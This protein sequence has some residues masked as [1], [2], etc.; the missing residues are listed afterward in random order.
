M[1]HTV[2]SRNSQ[3]ESVLLVLITAGSRALMA[4]G[5][6]SSGDT[7]FASA[8]STACAIWTHHAGKQRVLLLGSRLF[9]VG[10]GGGV[11]TLKS[12]EIQVS[13]WIFFSAG[14]AKLPFQGRDI[15]RQG[16]TFMVPPSKVQTTIQGTIPPQFTLGN[17][18]IYWPSLQNMDESLLTGLWVISSCKKRPHHKVFTQQG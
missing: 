15:N 14:V 6:A 5:A 4:R 11:K 13:I 9:L 8:L 1:L 7:V 16:L 18:Y 2:A 10:V 3:L 12:A 17:Q